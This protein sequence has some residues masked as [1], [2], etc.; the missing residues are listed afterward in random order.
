MASNDKIKEAQAKVDAVT[1]TMH[2]NLESA[3]KNTDRIVDLE[4]K[5]DDLLIGAGAFRDRANIIKK[6][7]CLNNF[8][9]KILWIAIILIIIG[10]TIGI[11]YGI[12]KSYYPGQ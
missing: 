11:I 3:L 8:K 7:M 10:V 9:M 2:K 4:E 6:R 5:S 12:V 1:L